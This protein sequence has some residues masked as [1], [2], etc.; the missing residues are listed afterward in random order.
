MSL[1]VDQLKLEQWLFDIGHISQ[2]LFQTHCMYVY[3]NCQLEVAM[4]VEGN[5][6][7]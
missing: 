3:P 1:F 7:I 6:P 5:L 4:D 2:D